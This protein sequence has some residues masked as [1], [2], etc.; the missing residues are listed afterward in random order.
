LDSLTNLS[1]TDA[2][3]PD[4]D[5]SSDWVAAE[6]MAQLRPVRRPTT[7]DLPAGFQVATSFF[8]TA[9][10]FTVGFSACLVPPSLQQVPSRQVRA[11]GLH[12]RDNLGD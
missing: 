1:M 2:I 9:K 10:A 7:S 8:Q 3:A 11:L 6:R 5:A 12:G 4:L